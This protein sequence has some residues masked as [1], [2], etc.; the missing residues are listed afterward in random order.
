MLI[1]SKL[2]PTKAR[3]RIPCR[4]IIVYSSW[5]LEIL[6]WFWCNSLGTDVPE[7]RGLGRGRVVPTLACMRWVARDSHRGCPCDET[8]CRA[9]GD[10]TAWG[11]ITTGLDHDDTSSRRTICGRMTLAGGCTSPGSAGCGTAASRA[12]CGDTAPCFGGRRSEH[13][14]GDKKKYRDCSNGIAER[15]EDFHRFT[16]VVSVVCFRPREGTFR[17]T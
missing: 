13:R 2:A 6:W 11:P 15:F 17:Q 4:Y 7:A 9:S 12:A 8:D 1:A 16:P 14:S 10:R 5:R 3:D